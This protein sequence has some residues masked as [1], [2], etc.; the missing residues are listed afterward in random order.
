[1]AILGYVLELLV[2][3]LQDDLH[4]LLL[5]PLAQRLLSLHIFI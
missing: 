5:L 4:L 1:L 2:G 3:G